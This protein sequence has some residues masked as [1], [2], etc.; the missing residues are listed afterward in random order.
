MNTAEKTGIIVGA[1][2]L[3]FFGL[4]AVASAAGN[5]E[6]EHDG[7]GDGGR[8]G[9]GPNGSPK[10]APGGRTWG[11]P[12]EDA[13]YLVP[14][15]FDP[16]RGLWISP[17]CQFVVEAPGFW[18]GL[19]RRSLN[20]PTLEPAVDHQVCDASAGA[21]TLRELWALS[22]TVGAVAHA[23]YWISNGAEPPEIAMKIVRELA[24]L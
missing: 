16:L 8:R 5:G 21:G 6:G 12:P 11:R 19:I 3:G 17:D 23:D 4:M 22:P 2:L 18:C 15:N 20:D 24:P 9:R 13:D 7:K 14:P 1:G 10:P